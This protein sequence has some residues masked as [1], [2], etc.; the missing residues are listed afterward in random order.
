[1]F[2]RDVGFAKRYFIHAV[3]LRFRMAAWEARI[4]ITNLFNRDPP[5]VDGNEVFSVS[6]V[7]IGNGYDLDGREVFASVKYRF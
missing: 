3:S 4:G 6:N 2:C 7:P 5:E 1:M